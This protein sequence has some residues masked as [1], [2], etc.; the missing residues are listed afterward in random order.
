MYIFEHKSVK[1]AAKLTF[2]GQKHALHL[3]LY[4]KF[5]QISKL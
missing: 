1:N 4:G 5:N 3:N 2:R